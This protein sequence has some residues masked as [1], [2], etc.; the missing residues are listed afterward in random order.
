MSRTLLLAFRGSRYRLCWWRLLELRGLRS[1]VCVSN[2]IH[3]QTRQR[4]VINLTRTTCTAL[5]RCKRDLRIALHPPCTPSFCRPPSAI[6]LCWLLLLP[7]FP[8]GPLPP[9]PFEQT[10]THSKEPNPN[11][12]LRKFS[13]IN[14]TSSTSKCGTIRRI[15]SG[16]VDCTTGVFIG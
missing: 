9:P 5:L 8:P 4:G 12:L 1:A 15:G 3:C 13:N 6:S 7:V 11:R 14:P 16:I 2:C 10:S